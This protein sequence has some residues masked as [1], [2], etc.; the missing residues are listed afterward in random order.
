MVDGFGGRYFPARKQWL[1]G[2]LTVGVRAAGEALR[3]YAVIVRQA[4]GSIGDYLYGSNDYMV[5]CVI[6]QAG[7]QRKK[8]WRIAKK[9]LTPVRAVT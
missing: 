9:L 5:L 4:T 8:S 1:E 2:I 3:N 6:F 7:R